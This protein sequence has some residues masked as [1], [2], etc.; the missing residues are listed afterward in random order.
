MLKMLRRQ[1]IQ[2]RKT[3][4]MNIHSKKEKIN[5]GLK[6]HEMAIYFRM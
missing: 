2:N 3:Y 6:E 5:I 4:V 1:K